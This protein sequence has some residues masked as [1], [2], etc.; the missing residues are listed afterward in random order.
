MFFFLLNAN[1][2]THHNNRSRGTRLGSAL[3]V[4]VCAALTDKGSPQD[5]ARI[6]FHYQNTVMDQYPAL[7]ALTLTNPD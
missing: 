1:L 5:C 7:R 3:L 2:C 6:D 4:S